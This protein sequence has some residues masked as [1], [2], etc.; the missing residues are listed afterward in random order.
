MA[1]GLLLLVTA[2]LSGEIPLWDQTMWPARPSNGYAY[3]AGAGTWIGGYPADR[4]TGSRSGSSMVPLTDDKLTSTVGQLWGVDGP[5]DNWVIRE[6]RF[7]QGGVAA[8]VTNDEDDAIGVTLGNDSVDSWYV[9]LHSCADRPPPLQSGGSCRLSLL[10]VENG[11]GVSLGETNVGSLGSTPTEIA[12]WRNGNR[13]V[14]QWD[15]GASVIFDDP[16]P[17]PGGLAGAWS[18][19]CGADGVDDEAVR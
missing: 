3:V 12:L 16:R 14:A 13:I 15:G 11:T 18:Y 7:I 1:P 6:P 2:A 8:M 10:R 4:W 9:A 19:D 5:T 17:L